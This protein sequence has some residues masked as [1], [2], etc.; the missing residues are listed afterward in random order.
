MKLK[1]KKCRQL[2][3]SVVIPLRIAKQELCRMKMEC[4]QK[5]EARQAIAFEK[6]EKRYEEQHQKQMMLLDL[7]IE[8]K[9]KQLSM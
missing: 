4:L 3:R 6:R 1:K 7:E 2:R 9:K 8:I 5:A